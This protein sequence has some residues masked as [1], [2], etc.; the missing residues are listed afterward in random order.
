M[1]TEVPPA[2]QDN[3]YRAELLTIIQSKIDE[4]PRSRQT[5]IGPSEIGGCAS[6]VAFKV[7]YGG[8]GEGDDKPGG[9]AAARGTVMHAWL[10]EI[11]K[12]T[13]RLMPDGSPRFLSDL[14]LAPV[15]EHVNGGTLD[16][17]DALYQRVIDWKCPGSWS[18]KQVRG[19]KVSMGYFLQTQ[20][21][22][23]GLESA[24][25]PVSDVGIMWLPM[26]TAA[27]HQ[28]ANGAILK[29]WDYDRQLAVDALER[30][31]AIKRLVAQFGFAAAFDMLDK[32]S[33]FCSDCPAHVSSGDRRATC[34]GVSGKSMD[35]KSSNPFA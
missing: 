26:D 34:Q 22:G 14:K 29:L 15:S 13:D 16:L 31:A 7:T 12:D 1:I 33:D 6:K 19:G 18:A 30:V 2:K 5:Q 23:Y 32:T 35:P 17:Y 10:D 20:V 3:I 8:D 28:T 9:W 24:G 25:Y 11:Y 21:Y 4:H 27:L